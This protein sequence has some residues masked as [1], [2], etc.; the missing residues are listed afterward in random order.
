[1]CKA[2]TIDLPAGKYPIIVDY[3]QGPATEIGMQLYWTPPGGAKEIVPARN[4]RLFVD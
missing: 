3:M 1:M 2:G 4:L